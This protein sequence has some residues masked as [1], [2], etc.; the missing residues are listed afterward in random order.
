MSR[1][2]YL[3]PGFF[4]DD[5][6]GDCS[7]LAR[8]LFA[9][10]WTIA[11]REGRLEDRPRRIKAQLLPFDDGSA[12]PLLRELAAHGNPPLIVRYRVGDRDYIAIPGWHN[13][14]KP[15][16]KEL[17]SVIPEPASNNLGSVQA[18]PRLCASTTQPGIGAPV[19][20]S[21][22]TSRARVTGTGT[23]TG[24]KNGVDQEPPLPPKPVDNS[25]SVDNS[26]DNSA[27][28]SG[29]VA[30]DLQEP[31]LEPPSD[32]TSAPP[33]ATDPLTRADSETC[34][35]KACTVREFPAAAYAPLRRAMLASLHPEQW[36]E[37]G[38]A[39][40]LDALLATYAQH[41]CAGCQ[42][43][44]GEFERP[45]LDGL[46]EQA[47]VAAVESLH[48]SQDVAAVM[49]SRLQRFGLAALVGDR[50]LE[51]LR[52]EKRSRSRKSEPRRIGDLA[53]TSGLK[54]T[55]DVDVA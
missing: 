38:G 43:S 9:G 6:L 51:E 54:T 27:V 34:D 3:K 44:L 2:R 21:K 30:S 26:V 47:V 19:T 41:V 15:H 23:L 37:V 14:Q 31:G 18:S 10:L 13:H 11:D 48:G 1:I 32:A 35:G 16:S 20:G 4:T 28:Q 33:P 42:A 45:Q 7:P 40:E 36:K 53:L 22:P 8:L 17:S 50:K 55:C 46:C 25:D 39:G 52:R 29:L 49:R 5:D 24:N 12:E